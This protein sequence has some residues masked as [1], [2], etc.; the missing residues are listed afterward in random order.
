ML[1]LCTMGKKKYLFNKGSQLLAHS[2]LVLT[3]FYT[4][5]RCALIWLSR[6]AFIRK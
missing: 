1:Q 6:N 2:K 5:K 3:A 4:T